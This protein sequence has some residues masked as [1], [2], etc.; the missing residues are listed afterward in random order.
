MIRT[1]IALA[2]LAASTVAAAQTPMPQLSLDHRMLLRCSSAFA[3]LANGQENGDA[4]A[5]RYPDVRQRG[6]EFFVRG[7]AQVM[8]EAGLD[9]IQIEVALS[10]EARDISENG[11]I[12]DVMPICLNLLPAE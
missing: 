11:T 5:L 6:R 3:L 9:R 1:A 2:L 7:A 10:A 4:A 8:E 12:E